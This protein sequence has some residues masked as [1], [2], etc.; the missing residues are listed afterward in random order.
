MSDSWLSAQ[1]SE[2]EL[3]LF[4]IVQIGKK[5]ACLTRKYRRSTLWG[6]VLRPA[7]N[8]RE[9]CSST[10]IFPLRVYRSV[11]SSQMNSLK[12]SPKHTGIRWCLKTTGVRKL[13]SF[14]EIRP[15]IPKAETTYAFMTQLSTCWLFTKTH[16]HE[17]QSLNISCMFN[18]FRISLQAYFFPADL[19]TLSSS[20][21]ALILQS[22]LFRCVIS[23][24]LSHFY[25]H[26]LV[27][28]HYFRLLHLHKSIQMMHR[29][30]WER[31]KKL[32]RRRF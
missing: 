20:L 12:T 19:P 7:A 24:F 26:L 16:T 2:S 22:L 4:G 10:R 30:S 14:K 25:P 31:L 18:L 28:K 11:K 27:L 1:F 6:A 13:Y 23:L 17:G 5:R 8:S 9:S 3:S 29:F 32:K 15:G 21:T